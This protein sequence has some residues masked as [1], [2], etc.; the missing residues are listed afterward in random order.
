MV[1]GWAGVNELLTAIRLIVDGR[2]NDSHSVRESAERLAVFHRM[3]FTRCSAR[4]NGVTFL[5]APTWVD[6]PT[7]HLR[8]V[9][10]NAMMMG[11]LKAYL[12]LTH[13]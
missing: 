2:Q 6:T 9:A 12:C 5:A 13:R 3:L 1:H 7:I 4:G 10:A 11:L 8:S